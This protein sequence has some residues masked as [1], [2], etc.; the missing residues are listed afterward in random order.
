VLCRLL[1]DDLVVMLA[2]AGAFLLLLMVVLE[3][4]EM[5]LVLLLLLLLQ[6]MPRGRR[7]GCELGHTQTIL[8]GTEQLPCRSADEGGLGAGLPMFLRERGCS[9]EGIESVLGGLC[10]GLLMSGGVAEMGSED[11]G[12]CDDLAVDWPGTVRLFLWGL[13]AQQRRDIET[14]RHAS[15][16]GEERRSQP[17]TR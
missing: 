5:V 16:G 10:F 15:G 4:A 8:C 9:G 3:E 2:L 7:H 17:C 1:V 11:D 12:L 14:S 13:V 6:D